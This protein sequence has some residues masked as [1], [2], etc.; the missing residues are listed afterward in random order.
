ML[1][2]LLAAAWPAQLPAPSVPSPMVLA[3]LDYPAC[4]PTALCHWSG[5]GGKEGGGV[6]FGG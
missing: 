1:A 4:R 3:Q 6:D 2:G 5:V